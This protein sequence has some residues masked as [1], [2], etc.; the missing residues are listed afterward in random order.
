MSIKNPMYESVPR[1]PDCGGTVTKN[2]N[3]WI[4]DECHV[5]SQMV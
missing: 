3:S 5:E 4:C 2:Y 1:C